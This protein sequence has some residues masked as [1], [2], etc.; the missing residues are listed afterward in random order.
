MDDLAQAIRYA[1]PAN[2]AALKALR[3]SYQSDSSVDQTSSIHQP[4]LQKTG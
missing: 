1:Q 4:Q 3:D 2:Q